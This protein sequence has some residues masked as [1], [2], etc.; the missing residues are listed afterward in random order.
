MKFTKLSLIAVLAVTSGVAA[1]NT[2]TIAGKGQVYYYTTDNTGAGD[3]TDKESTSAAAAVTL[4]V[5]HQIVDGVTANF[6]AVGHSHLGNSVGQNK[7]EGSNTG[8]YFNVANLTG[9]FGDT[10]FIAGRQLLDTPML[11]S[12]DWLLA[13]GSFEA[14]TMANKSIENVT[15]I[16]S[17]VN[18]MRANN[19]GDNFAKLR[20]DNYAFGAVYGGIVDA[21]LWYYNVDVADYTQIYLDVSKKIGEVT[22][23]GQGAT[24]DYGTGDDS[25]AYGLKVASS[26]AGFDLSAAYNNVD[27]RAAGMVGVDSMYTSSWNVFASQDIG[28]SWKVDMA[29][30]FSGISTTLSYAD[31]ETVG[32]ELDVILGYSIADNISMDTIFTS[33]KYGEDEDEDADNALE[34]IATYTF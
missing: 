23:S 33:T 12:F 15:L 20:D 26:V 8:G 2:T 9:T 4:D 29:K 17:Y 24:T 6:S 3:L 31:Y 27:D 7:M 10:T 1:E 5:S 21:N 14:Y 22:L 25:T 11:G 32:N 30:E 34:L 19:T 16:A 28:A 13:P 18:K